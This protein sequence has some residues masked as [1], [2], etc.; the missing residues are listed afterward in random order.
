MGH[1]LTL[2]EAA[3]L[4]RRSPKTI[5]TWTSKRKI[6]HEKVLGRV[7]FDAE[8]LAKWMASFRVETEPKKD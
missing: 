1:K 4:V 2:I 3:Q 8:E 7:L 5:Y 6:P